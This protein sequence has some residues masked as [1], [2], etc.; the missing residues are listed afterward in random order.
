MDKGD[1]SLIKSPAFIVYATSSG[2]RIKEL[3]KGVHANLR[4]KI[5]VNFFFNVSLLNIFAT[6]N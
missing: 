2:A 4:T 3:K 1:C 5:I 6:C